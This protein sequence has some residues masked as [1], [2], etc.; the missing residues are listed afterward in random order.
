[1]CVGQDFPSAVLSWLLV[2]VESTACSS[3]PELGFSCFC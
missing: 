2:S 1:M 3:V